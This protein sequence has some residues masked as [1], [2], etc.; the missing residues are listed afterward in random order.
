MVLRDGGVHGAVDRDILK[1]GE[2]GP[3]N[4]FDALRGER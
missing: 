4:L 3:G 1:G 2:M